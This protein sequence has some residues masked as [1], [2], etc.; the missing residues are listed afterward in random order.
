M[1][2]NPNA[3][4]PDHRI[5]LFCDLDGTV[6]PYGESTGSPEANLIFA[7]LVQR[8]EIVL[9]YVTGR[10]LASAK[11]VII[12][13][14]LPLPHYLAADVGSTIERVENGAYVPMQNWWTA[15]GRDWVGATPESILARLTRVPG[16]R[17]Q[18][19]EVQNTYKVCFY[20]DYDA[21]G[22]VLVN[23]VQSALLD[24]RIRS[25]VLWSRDDV[26][27]VGYLDVMPLGA[28][29]LGAVRWLLSQTGISQEHAV[30][31]GDSGN[32]LP[33]L[34]SGIRSVMP[35]NGQESVLKIALATLEKKER[36]FSK[37][38]YHAKGGFLGLDGNVLGG[39]L[40]G[41]YMHFPQTREWMLG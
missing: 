20:T 30:F 6:S 34:A 14:K 5:F 35:R 19:P 4:A 31:A 11:E 1:K 13:H 39:V 36:G 28:G 41:L 8:N 16:I 38:L 40:E 2:P 26:L 23:K 7:K 29:K 24:L 33:V 9:A 22:D 25:Q 27:H 17:P 18:E 3:A 32:D 10:T 21:Q 37:R 15:I 12:T